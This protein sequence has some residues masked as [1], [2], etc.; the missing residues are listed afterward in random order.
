MFYVYGVCRKKC[1][2]QAEKKVSS[3]R[4]KDAPSTQQEYELA[5]A[6]ITEEVFKKAKAVCVSGELSTP[7][8]VDQFIELAERSGQYKGLKPMRKRPAEDAQGNPVKTKSGRHRYEY[9]PVDLRY[10][11]EMSGPCS[12]VGDIGGPQKC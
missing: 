4:G 5:V 3:L 12:L 8:S 9:V 6:E 11:N 1:R 2:T 7:S 10:L